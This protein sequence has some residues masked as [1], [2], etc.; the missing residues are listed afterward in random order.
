MGSRGV[1]LPLL[2]AD[3]PPAGPLAA[4]ETAEV[5][6]PRFA[7]DAVVVPAGVRHNVVNTSNGW[8]KLYTIYSPPEHKEG[9]V[10]QTKEDALR[11]KH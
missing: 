8:M 10:H 9:T 7:P 2:T 1:K 5:D 6:R 4:V 3:G 11:E